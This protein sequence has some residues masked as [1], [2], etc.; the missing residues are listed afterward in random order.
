MARLQVDGRNE[1]LTAAGLAGSLHD[2]VAVDAEFLSVQ[3][4][5]CVYVI[6]MRNEE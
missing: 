6:Q 1:Y 2:G 4:A 5:V 3:V